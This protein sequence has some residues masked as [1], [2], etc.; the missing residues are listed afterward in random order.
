M[1]FNFPNLI[2]IVE[3]SR[4]PR[5]PFLFQKK[6]FYKGKEGKKE[7]IY[8][9]NIYTCKAIIRDEQFGIRHGVWHCHWPLEGI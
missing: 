4:V 2:S 1:A 3:L 7:L 8:E 5:S 9:L 6:H